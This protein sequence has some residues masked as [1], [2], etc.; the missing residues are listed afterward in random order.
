MDIQQ[1][2]SS[3]ILLIGDSCIDKYHYGLCERLSP[4]APVPVFKLLKT[5]KK[6]GMA[7]N[8]CENLTSLGNIVVLLTNTE[9]ITKERYVENTQK[10]HLIRVDTGEN[11]SIKPFK[12][13]NFDLLEFKDFDCVVISDYNKGYLDTESILQILEF[14]K[15]NKLQVFIDSKKNDLSI[16]ENC[17]IKINEYEFSLAKQFPK[18]CELILTRGKNGATHNSI[19][20]QAYHNDIDNT[21]LP[22]D[23]CGAGDTFLAAFVTSY[24]TNNNISE[25]IRFAN[26]CASIAVKNFGTYTIQL[27]DL[28]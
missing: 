19:N 4:E 11:S 14:A 1:L 6:Q 12:I 26:K 22:V 8:V 5:V 15:S 28:K 13:N 3:K 10:Q 7:G 24:L 2:K 23:V 17:F 25:A 16:Y 9:L 27:E 18:N 21:T 20:Y